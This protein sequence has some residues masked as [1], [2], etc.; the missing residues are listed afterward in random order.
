MALR[1]P[2]VAVTVTGSLRFIYPDGLRPVFKVGAVNAA[3]SVLLEPGSVHIPDAVIFKDKRIT[4]PY[5]G[6]NGFICSRGN[7]GSGKNHR[8][9]K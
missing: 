6:I 4:D 8:S 2:P 5:S 3:V 1:S 7:S 9:A